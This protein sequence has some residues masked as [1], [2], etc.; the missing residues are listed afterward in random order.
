ME[1]IP[2]IGEIASIGTSIAFS[3]GPIF[4]TLAVNEVGSVVVNRMRLIVALIA[5]LL[6]H[7]IG[8]G[9]ALPIN[10]GVDKW[11][12]FALSGIIGLTL[13][14]AAL[15]QA[16]KLIGPRITMLIF[17]TSPI[18]SALFGVLF[19]GEFLKSIQ[20]IGILITILSAAYVS[21]HQDGTDGKYDTK[22][23]LYKRGLIFAV[24]GALGQSLGLITAKVGL[25]DGF[26]SIT[27][28]LMRMFAGMLA[29]WIWTFF[30]KEGLQTIK[31]FI[32]NKKAI[33]M[34]L[35]A[36]LIGPTIG[37]WLSLIAVQNTEIGIASTLQS[38]SP[39][40]ILPLSYWIFKEKINRQS[41]IGTLIALVGISF[42]FLG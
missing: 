24:I 13:G 15:F 8:F 37:V 22:G 35:I 4:F 30:K 1:Q 17:A 32:S 21:S 5:I 3:F 33:K 6:I 16:L 29:L 26:P 38:L 18:I 25:D 11:F 41:L 14:D 23:P 31:T 40:F 36:S 10:V 42:L 39:I 34:I 20:Y 9:Y 12:W 27:G 28:L 19:F 2:Y 7:S